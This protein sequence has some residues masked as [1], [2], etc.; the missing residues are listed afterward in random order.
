[1][2]SDICGP[3][4]TTSLGGADYIVV[5]KD[6]CSHYRF[7]YCIKTRSETFDCLR[8]TV[9]FIESEAGKKVKKFYSDRGSEYTSNRTQ[10]YLL[11]N[12]IVHKRSIPFV[13]A[14]N[15]FIER[16][17]RT[18]LNDI[19]SMLYGSRVPLRFWAEAADT[20]VYLLNRSLNS[21]ISKT[22]YELL[23][24]V[25]RRVTHLRIFGC[26]C[27]VKT[28]TKKRSGYRPKL[29]ARAVKGMMLGYDRDYSYKVFILEEKKIIFSR[30]IAFDETKSAFDKPEDVSNLFFDEAFDSDD[31]EDTGEDDET[32]EPIQEE[33]DDETEP[34]YNLRNRRVEESHLILN[35]P[36]SLK[37][38]MQS[39][40]SKNRIKAAED[41]FNSLIKNDTWELVQ[42]P[43][44][45][46]AIT[47]KWVFQIKMRGE[48][49]DRYKCRLVARGF[50]QRYRIDYLE[51]F[52]PV[53]CLESIRILLDLANQFDLGDKAI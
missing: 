43:E 5:F 7:I 33:P 30:D 50:T 15:G 53:V 45:K 26:L 28:Q 11:E 23:L 34:R 17:N 46:R 12:K 32:R 14:Q 29:E 41:E 20:F 24:G 1:L 36:S 52:S 8:K 10:E 22:P 47:S 21:K 9:A 6:E 2:H 48:Q 44:G 16:D 42:L 38:A 35:E 49:I 31:S 13:P 37:G 27:Y 40:D 18:L 51:T 3:L 39:P 4:G 25:K 19:R